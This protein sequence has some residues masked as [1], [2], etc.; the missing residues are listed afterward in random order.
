M[1]E[2]RVAQWSITMDLL[3]ELGKVG[4]PDTLHMGRVLPRFHGRFDQCL[5]LPITPGNV[6]T[7]R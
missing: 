3:M 6:S 4:R 5:K 7:R 2:A 1:A